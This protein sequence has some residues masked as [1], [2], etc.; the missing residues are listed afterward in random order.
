MGTKEFDDVSFSHQYP[1]KLA[2]YRI[3]MN[4]LIDWMSAMGLE[5]YASRYIDQIAYL[6]LPRFKP[7]DS[8]YRTP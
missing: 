6:T 5:T 2:D 1:Q 7:W 8:F 4:D 3:T